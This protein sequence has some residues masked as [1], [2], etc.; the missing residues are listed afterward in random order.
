[1]AISDSPE[2][3]SV[4]QRITRG[5][6]RT[7]S[8]WRW[9]PL[10]EVPL[11]NRRRAD[12]MA[13]SPKGDVL[14][15]EIKSGLPDFQADRKWPDYQPYCDGFAFAVDPAFPL[16]SLP[17]DCGVILCDGWDAEVIR[18][19]PVHAL[20]ASRRKAVTLTFGRLAASRLS[21]ADGTLQPFSDV[22]PGIK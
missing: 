7:L 3:R 21:S 15:I 5:V 20:H 14:I 11:A 9:A 18:P 22:V 12:V 17:D 19:W 13:L 6:I 16:E 8:N 2:R 4:T 1:M 10:T